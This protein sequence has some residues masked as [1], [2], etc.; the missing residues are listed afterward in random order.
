[1]YQI[2]SDNAQT[3]LTLSEVVTDAAMLA[4][5]MLARF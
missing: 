2:D 3:I 4:W 5:M 1:M